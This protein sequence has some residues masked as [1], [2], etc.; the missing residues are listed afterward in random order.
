MRA[1]IPLSLVMLLLG[2]CATRTSR[3]AVAESSVNVGNCLLIVATRGET[4]AEMRKAVDA[5]GNISM[6][7]GVTVRAAGTPLDQIGQS[8]ENAYNVMNCFGP[9]TQ[10]SV[11]RSR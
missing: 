4:K 8:I 10:V 7:F 3:V 6:P 5:A 2:G 9:P 1:L 11:T